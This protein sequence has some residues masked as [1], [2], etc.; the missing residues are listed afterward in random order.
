MSGTEVPERSAILE[1]DQLKVNFYTR[2]G[3][4]QAVR[5][6]SFDIH[7]G[8]VL[9][10]V[11]ESGSGKSVTS[12]AIM[13]LTELPGKV[14]SGDIRWKGSSLVRGSGSRE[15]MRRVR[16]REIS[17]VFQD[18]MTSLNPVFTIGNQM[19]EATRRHLGLTE[20]GGT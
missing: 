13:G 11:G 3:V 14:L 8:E 15:L 6:V 16:G 5:G 17:M 19:V 4:V 18:P 7:S 20:K 1:V 2:R 9:G 10:L 12:Q